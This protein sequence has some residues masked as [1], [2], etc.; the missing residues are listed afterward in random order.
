MGLALAA[1]RDD[2]FATGGLDGSP[3]VLAFLGPSGV[4]KTE[5]A[6]QVAVV[7]H[8]HENRL[9][10]HTARDAS[11]RSPSPPSRT[12]GST[13]LGG[14]W[15]SRA[16]RMAAVIAAAV[17]VDESRSSAVRREGSR[18]ETEIP[19]ILMILW[20]RAARGAAESQ[21]IDFL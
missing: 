5:L 18:G 11:G 6:K 2:D 19:P 17:A 14:V 12:V 16:K 1:E 15:S 20:L 4:G 7:L 10:G 8:G 3:L 13:P 9:D 21:S